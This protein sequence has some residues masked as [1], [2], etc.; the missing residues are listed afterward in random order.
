M[1]VSVRLLGGLAVERGGRA[2]ALRYEAA[3]LLLA[4]LALHPGRDVPRDDL[5]ALLWPDAAPDAG[6]R[7]LREVL[8]AL[9]RDLGDGERAEPVLRAG[10]TAI[11]LHPALPSDAGPLLAALDAADRHAHPSVAACPAC[12]AAL[13]PA[14]VAPELLAGL[15]LPGGAYARR[16]AALRGRVRAAREALAA[17]PPDPSPHLPAPAG[18]LVGRR[19]ELARLHALL[20]RP[21]VRLVTLTGMGGVGKT[22]LAAEAARRHGPA[23]RD[24]ARWV[25]AGEA[26]TADELARAVQAA[27][28]LGGTAAPTALLLDHLRGRELLLVLDELEGAA[29]AGPWV[30]GI[31]AGAAGVRILATS[32]VRLACRAEHVLRVDGLPAP[33]AAALLLARARQVEPDLVADD[34]DVAAL[35]AALGGL[36]LALELAA[37]QV[38][39]TPLAAVRAR[40]GDGL[41]LADG[42]DDLPPAHRSVR[43]LLAS[44]V[45]RLSPDARSA[46]AALAVFRGP[47][48]AADAAA[49]GDVR[50]DTLAEL[51]R[52]SLL[53]EGA[54]GLAMHP[55]VAAWAREQPAP[56]DHAARHRRCVLGGLRSLGAAGWARR[57]D[58]VRA[59]WAS[60][61]AESDRDVLADAAAPLAAT[62][63]AA[64]AWHDAD[65]AFAAA[66]AALADD[67]AHPALRR[68]LVGAGGTAFRLGRH[69]ESLAALREAVD[70]AEAAGDGLDAARARHALGFA[71]RNG[72]APAAARPLLEAAADGLD[73]VG[74]AAE[75]LRARAD[76]ATA[77]YEQGDV[78]GAAAALATL[79]PALAAAGDPTGAESAASVLGLC[80]VLG[81]DLSGLPRIEASVR[82]LARRG[83][84]SA[85]NARNALACAAV[86]AGRFAD[87][88][89]HAEAAARAYADRGFLPG[90]AS[91][92][93]WRVMGLVG[94]GRRDEA[95]PALTAALDAALALGS[96]RPALEAAAA[97]AWWDA[98]PRGRGRPGAGDRAARLV[99]T[100]SAHPEPIAELRAAVAPLAA[101]LPAAEPLDAEALRAALV[102]ARAALPG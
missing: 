41:G 3:G 84:P 39:G 22:R 79:V 98:G 72:G 58:D 43:A 21:E 100:V 7:R 52:A 23:H 78:P 36:P 20:T 102:R 10:R 99:P 53:S 2:L 87:A 81:G 60:A 68:C 56:P 80:E 28:G 63:H 32:R 49:V 88:T 73:A 16:I 95:A 67:R 51:T 44:G 4:W 76:A 45:D 5:A 15:A 33:D 13:A 61:L 47:F 6:R 70:L 97:L 18:V 57:R 1:D 14:A 34:G 30:A 59:A 50:P 24:G 48:D 66:V 69:A 96:P 89:R 71:L 75:A 86:L 85:V 74:H 77:R 101:A 38:D 9:R 83:E 27:L 91:T 55:L 25:A 40:V 26:R 82:A 92:E 35:C 94:D 62:V 54:A 42:L 46:L 29:G 93:T 17:P 90:V 11:G 64:H 8:F 12:R 37:A 19:D 65:A 31:L